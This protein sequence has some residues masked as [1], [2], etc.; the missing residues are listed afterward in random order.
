MNGVVIVE[1][2]VGYICTGLAEGIGEGVAG[3]I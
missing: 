3:F 1:N 2:G